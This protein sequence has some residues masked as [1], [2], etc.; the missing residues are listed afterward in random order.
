[1]IQTLT[2]FSETF[3]SHDSDSS[4]SSSS[5]TS[6]L[7]Q[8]IKAKKRM[9]M[10]KKANNALQ[11][12]SIPP[13]DVTCDK[14]LF[15]G[16]FGSVCRGKWHGDVLIYAFPL[17]KEESDFDSFWQQVA[18]LSRLRHE[19][20][21]LFMGAVLEPVPCIVTSMNKGPSL[22]EQIHI[23]KESLSMAYRISVGR[24]VAQAVGYLHAKDIILQK[25][26]NSHNI[27][28]E[29]K[30]KL[31]L[32]D[33]RMTTSTHNPDTQVRE[34][35]SYLSP[36]LVRSLEVSGDELILK[37]DFTPETDAYAFGTLLFELV[38]YK[39]PFEKLSLESIVWRVGSGERESLQ[40]LN[41]SSS[42]KDL[43]NQC[44]HSNP[45]QRLKFR[46]ILRLLQDCVCIQKTFSSS[47]P[48]NLNYIGQH[49][50]VTDN[51]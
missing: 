3:L 2:T 40:K 4:S 27:I 42:L 38:A 9:K 31:C 32:I 21:Q 47:E 19:N 18:A 12:W 45:A 6:S 50:R 17:C 41:C 33:Q 35:L 51:K 30:V 29:T 22:Y 25:R 34:E 36:E 37:N 8:K 23:K 20:L 7:S 10:S 39:F 49:E 1:M 5:S 28:L 13:E 16:H 26:L 11:E 14:V 46:Q 43:I 15:S 44:W 24:Q 48:E